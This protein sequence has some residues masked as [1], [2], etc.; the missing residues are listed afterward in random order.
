MALEKVPRWG[1][2]NAC[3]AQ[4]WDDCPLLAAWTWDGAVFFIRDVSGKADT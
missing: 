2:L 4:S 1:E 3:V